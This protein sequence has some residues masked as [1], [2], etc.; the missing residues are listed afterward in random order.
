MHV[1]DFS[2]ELM[3]APMV[4]DSNYGS[5]NGPVSESEP[6]RIVAISAPSPHTVPPRFGTQS[7]FP[8]LSL[9]LPSTH[10]ALQAEPLLLHVPRPWGLVSP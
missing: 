10:P 7:S 5:P 4:I 8:K 1:Q 3:A 9:G 6:A 2:L